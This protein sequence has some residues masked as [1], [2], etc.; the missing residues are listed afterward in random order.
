M[1]YREIKIQT[2]RDAEERLSLQWNNWIYSNTLESGD[3]VYIYRKDSDQTTS[4]N[5]Y[6][7]PDFKSKIEFIAKHGQKVKILKKSKEQT[8]KEMQ[9]YWFEI[10]IEEKKGWI[11]G[12][13]LHP[14]PLME[15]EY[16]QKLVEQ[17]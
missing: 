9:S 11:W 16:Y 6:R 3:S 5:I 7:T 13:Y 10:N 4:V 15:E 2:A 12:E 17:E 8:Y 14:N 1:G